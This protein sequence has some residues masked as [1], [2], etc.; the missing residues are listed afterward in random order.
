MLQHKLAIS[1]RNKIILADEIR[2]ILS[3]L[4]SPTLKCAAN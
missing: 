3:Q 2:T 4:V 1:P